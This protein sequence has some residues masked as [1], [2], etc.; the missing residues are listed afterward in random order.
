A[1]MVKRSLLLANNGFNETL[2]CAEDYDLWLRLATANDL[3]VIPHDIGSYRKREGSLT[4]SERPIYYC[5]DL[6]IIQALAKKAFAP[7]R[8]ALKQRLPLVYGTFCYYYRTHKMRWSAL[9]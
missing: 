4:R 8:S 9:R 2:H 1:C 7:Y 5:E 6:M 3:Y